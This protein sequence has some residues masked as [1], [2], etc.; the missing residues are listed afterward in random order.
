MRRILAWTLA[1]TMGLSLCACGTDSSSVSTSQTTDTVAEQTPAAE[2]SDTIEIGTAEELVTFAKS[3]TDG[4]K[5]GYTG[6]TVV[7]T[8]D[9]DCSDV[10]W[11]LINLEDMS[12]YSC[13][14]QGVF[15]GQGHTISNV[16]FDSD[17]PICGAGIIGMNLSEV[18]NLTAQNVRIHC[19]VSRSSSSLYFAE[20]VRVICRY[21]AL[22]N[23]LASVIMSFSPFG[24]YG[25]IWFNRDYTYECAV[26]EMPA[27]YADALMLCSPP[28]ALRVVVI[29]GIMISI[30]MY[31]I[32][33]KLFRF[34]D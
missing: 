29:T 14:F 13:M 34:E 25:Q 19:T 3:V 22:G 7:L 31:R 28:R 10:E 23:L 15:D 6:Q 27:G 5:G 33:E 1:L 32:A 12:D 26:E 2:T 24:Y 4:S 11:T 18:K 30:V 16:T 20:I 17:Y 8:A 9:I 21:R